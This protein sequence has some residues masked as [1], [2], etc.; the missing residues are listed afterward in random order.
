MIRPC[1]HRDLNTI[2]EIIN[3]AAKAYQGNI[4]ADCYHEPYMDFEDLRS[5]VAAGVEFWGWEDSG[6]LKG[7][8]GIQQVKDVTLVRHAYVRTDWQGKGIGSLLLKYLLEKTTGRILVGTWAAAY[9]AIGLYERHGFKMTVPTEKDSLL[10]QYWTISARQKET[11]VVL[12]Q[13][14]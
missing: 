9:W 2:H 4:P 6:S 12:L 1:D 8:M 14:K 11:S 10:D 7:V 5:E 3:D 13:D